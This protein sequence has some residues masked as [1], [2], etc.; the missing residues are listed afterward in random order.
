MKIH[1]HLKKS[2]H[3]IYYLRLQIKGLDRRWSLGTRDL[4]QALFESHKLG[5]KILEMKINQINTDK[6]KGWT[7][8]SDGHIIKV[9]TEDNDADRKSAQ[10]ALVALVQAQALKS[11]QTI[12]KPEPIQSTISIS[13]ALIEYTTYISKTNTVEKSQR[14]ALSAIKHMQKIL[15]YDFNMSD[16]NDEVI[17]DRWMQQRSKEVAQTTVKRDLSF[18]R[19]FISWGADKKRKYCPAKLTLTMDAKGENWAYLDKNDLLNIFSNLHTYAVKPYQLWIPILGLYTGARISELAGLKVS[20]IYEKSG[21]NAIHLSGTKTDA[22]DRHIPVHPDLIRLGFIDYIEARRAKNEVQLFD[23]SRSEGGK[24][25]SKW[26]TAYKKKIG[27][28]HKHK[29]FHSFRPTLVDHLKQAGC[30]FEARCQYVGHDSGGGVHNKIYGR[31]ELSLKL[32]QESVVNKINWVEYCDFSLD[33]ET[34]KSAADALTLT[35]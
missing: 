26:Y 35:K 13:D 22:S 5:A 17:E 12:S 27:M 28:N 10:E 14:M 16:L 1:S 7:L 11:Q 31:N 29:V 21:L 20:S 18:I 15:G 25:V 34:L 4:N 24:V 33:F 23:I 3:G 2:R 19:S 30:D 8:E 32:I 6:I 9:K